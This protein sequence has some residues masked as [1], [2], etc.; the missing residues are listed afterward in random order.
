MGKWPQEIQGPRE[1]R[2]NGMNGGDQKEVVGGDEQNRQIKEMKEMRENTTE[3]TIE[4]NHHRTK[5]SDQR[6]CWA[7]QN[8]EKGGQTAGPKYQEL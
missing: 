5:S 1:N 7:R 6:V 8:K 2:E 3:K 4:G